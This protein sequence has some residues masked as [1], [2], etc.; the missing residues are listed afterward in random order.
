MENETIEVNLKDKD[1]EN[2]KITRKLTNQEQYC[3]TED[4][5]EY[6]PFCGNLNQ[7]C[8]LLLLT[9]IAISLQS[10]YSLFFKII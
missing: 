2:K 1:D 7:N 10:G 8:V 3:D 5:G 4:M 9:P 6:L